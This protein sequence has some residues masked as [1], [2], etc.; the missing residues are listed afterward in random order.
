M[1]IIDDT[2][3]WE[4]M[5]GLIKN[6]SGK[7]RLRCCCLTNPYLACTG[8]CDE[9]GETDDSG[10]TNVCFSSVCT[11][12]ETMWSQSRPCAI[13]IMLPVY[14]QFLLLICALR[15][16]ISIYCCM[17]NQSKD[18]T[19][20]WLKHRVWVDTTGKYQFGMYSY[21]LL[22]I[23]VLEIVFLTQYKD[24]YWWWPNGYQF[25][26]EE[27]TSKQALNTTSIPTVEQA[28]CTIDNSIECT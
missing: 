16:N 3:Y 20:E 10:L 4:C 26:M 7:W 9:N 18:I 15:L 17:L 1:R 2:R 14:I 13:S 21:G 22:A 28:S 19:C 24:N 11:L 8:A 5:F 27:Y 12:Q 23:L 25:K 6:I